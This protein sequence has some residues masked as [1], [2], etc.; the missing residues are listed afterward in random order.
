MK[1]EEGAAPVLTGGGRPWSVE[2]ST[3]ASG[4]EL[5]L[6]AVCG[7]KQ[8]KQALVAV[9]HKGTCLEDAGW[10]RAVGGR[11]AGGGPGKDGTQGS[12]APLIG[13]SVFRKNH[14][15]CL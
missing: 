11:V 2:E 10:L 4:W 14:P 6:Q 15:T 1:G 9:G 5:C 7:C 3:L 13:L 12:S 8:Q